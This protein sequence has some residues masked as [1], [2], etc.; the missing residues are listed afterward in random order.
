MRRKPSKLRKAREACKWQGFEVA[1]KL[2]MYVI[3]YMAIEIEWEEPTEDEIRAIC[4]LFGTSAQELALPEDK[5]L[6]SG[7]IILLEKG[8]IMQ[9]K[10]W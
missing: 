9:L 2:G 6:F 1:E 5:A 10:L 7:N 3:R 8:T 4:H